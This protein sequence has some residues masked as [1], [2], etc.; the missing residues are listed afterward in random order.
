VPRRFALLPENAAGSAE[1][2]SPTSG[3]G[4]LESVLVGV[5]EHQDIAGAT[6][7]GHDRYQSVSTE[8]DRGQPYVLGHGE[9]SY[10]QVV[11]LSKTVAALYL[12]ESPRAFKCWFSH[13]SA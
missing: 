5:R 2:M 1:V 8:P 3:E 6:L 9:R 12:A 10:R 4:T 13:Q 7:L 11:R